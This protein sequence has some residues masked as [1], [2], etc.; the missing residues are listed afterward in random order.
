MLD[1]IGFTVSAI[2]LILTSP[3]LVSLFISSMLTYAVAV[4]E[5]FSI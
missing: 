1:E 2:L 4:E 5:I 3:V